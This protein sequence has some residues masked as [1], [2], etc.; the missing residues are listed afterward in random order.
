MKR[1]RPSMNAFTCAGKVRT[2]AIAHI[3][4]PGVVSAV[5]DISLKGKAQPL[6]FLAQQVA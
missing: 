6:L 5:G 4:G 1:L 2:V 3:A